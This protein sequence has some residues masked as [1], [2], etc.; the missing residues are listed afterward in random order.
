MLYGELGRQ[1]PKFIIWQ[2]MANFWKKFNMQQFIFMY[3]VPIDEQ[4]Y[5]IT[6]WHQRLKQI[7]IN[8][9]I[10]FAQIYSG[11]IA[12]AEFKKYVKDRCNERA[13]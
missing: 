1:E 11:Y 3:N 13:F 2:R 9:G 7:L 5:Q 10:S 12:D 8:S 4:K 6:A